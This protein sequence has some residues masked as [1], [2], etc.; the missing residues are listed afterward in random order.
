ML[1]L[2]C[3]EKI[4]I[5]VEASGYTLEVIESLDP[6]WISTLCD[7]CDQNI[8]D[9]IGCGYV[10]LIGPLVPAEVNAANLRIGNKVYERLLGFRPEIALVN[11]QA[12]SEGL[13]QHYLDAGFKVIIMEWNNPS[14]FHPEWNPEWRYLPQAAINQHGE[15]ISLIWNESIAFQKFQRYVHGE[16]ELNEYL[17][18]LEQQLGDTPRAFCLYGNDAE[19]FDFRPG[20]FQT[21]A[22]LRE[23]GEW[24]RIAKL[25]RHLSNDAQ[26]Q[27]IHASSVLD[28]IKQPNSLNPL[29]LESP[30]QPVPVKKQEKYN[31]TRWAVTGLNDL[32][33]NTDCWQIYHSLTDNCEATEENW[34]ELC[35]LW[36]SDFRTH[37]TP[38]RL[39]NYLQRLGNFKY[40][41]LSQPK[42]NC[43]ADGKTVLETT[44]S[45]SG[46]NSSS[47]LHKPKGNTYTIVTNGRF[48]HVESQHINL[49]LNCRKGLA[50]HSLRFDDVCSTPLIKTIPHGY[51]DDI[52]MG[53]DFYS[54]H[55]IFE[56]PGKPKIT[57][58]EPVTP[59]ID[60][61]C[62]GLII[63]SGSIF[64]PLGQIKKKIFVGIDAQNKPY[65]K[66]F[67][68][69]NWGKKP[70][71]SLRL[72]AVTLNPEAFDAD[73]LF[74]A[75]HNG[76]YDI[77]KFF[78]NGRVVSH[79]APPSFLVSASHGLGVTADMVVLGD[80][81]KQIYLNIQK[82]LCSA[83]GLITHRNVR[84]NFFSRHIFSLVEMDETSDRGIGSVANS[85]PMEF[86]V[87]ISA[88]KGF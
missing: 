45:P 64:T 46:I 67:Y 76:G 24:K 61:I 65:V 78:L 77:E 3:E 53:A 42:H 71:G 56:I 30:E 12:Y 35:Y 8:V 10:Q 19:I 74:Y 59:V 55:L 83:I 29:A 66:I 16:I 84:P 31:L 48:L 15:K 63:V 4:P 6:G 70:I 5:G 50:I 75:T 41:M 26:F 17:K 54:G 32:R 85:F 52:S 22:V 7:L 47:Q 60:E 69:L 20:R 36:S 27:F 58:L 87:K 28:L 82:S 38:K 80:Q 51:Y 1:N 23:G 18:H 44:H 86:V 37:I 34:K 62:R 2:A 72:G 33:V 11:E 43:F 68:K 25:L 21:E 49:I 9:F 88:G 40:K 13:L 79:G 81:K 73:S 14:R 39:K 57:D